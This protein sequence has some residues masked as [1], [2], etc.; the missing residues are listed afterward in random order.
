MIETGRIQKG[1][2]LSRATEFKKG[3]HWR[4]RKPHWDRDW[5]VREY[6][7]KQRSTGDIA[8]EIGTTDGN[9]LYWMRK[10]N[11]PRR[12]VAEARTLKHWGQSGDANPMF[13]K[14]GKDV[15]SW[16]GGCTPERQRFYASREWATACVTVWKRD[17]ATCQCCL[18]HS[19][20]TKL[21]VHHIVSFAV[22]ELRAEPTNLIL[23]CAGCHRWVHSRQNKKGLFIKQYDGNN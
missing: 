18:I 14:R 21:H 22:S 3:Q 9:V 13:G 2:H 15:P 16:K 12:S 7:T 20:D 8:L 4:P 6:V 23:L 11:I 1:Q 17:K 5:F 19:T 10:H